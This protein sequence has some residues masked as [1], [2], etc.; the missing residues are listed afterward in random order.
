MRGQ[1]ATRMIVAVGAAGWALSGAVASEMTSGKWTLQRSDAPGMVQISMRSPSGRHEFSNTYN[2]QKSEFTGLD[3]QQDTQFTLARDAGKFE[4][5][6]VV[7]DGAGAGSFQFVAD[8]HYAQEMRAL[9]FDGVDVDG[10]QI[11]FA[12]LDVS[13]SFARAIKSAD[14]K[15]LSTD[16]LLAFRIHGVTPEMVQRVRAA[17]YTPDSSA[18]IAMRI[19]G[20][21]PEW[22]DD[23]KRRGYDGVPMEQ[24]IAFRIHGVT[25]DF[26]ED[27]QKLGFAHPQPEQLVAMRIHGV[28]PD[29]IGQLQARGVKELTIDKLVAMKIHG[30]D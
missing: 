6:G 1:W 7:N 15:G 30:I 17:G 13:L 20:A 29:Y 4:F 11:H 16:Q 3:L 26:I 19:H 24:L 21:T 12:V 25:P 28:T 22:M 5:E 2:S 23:L 14:V 9:G 8:P 27:V 10:K 18:L